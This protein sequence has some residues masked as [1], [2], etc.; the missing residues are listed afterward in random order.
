MNALKPFCMLTNVRYWRKADREAKRNTV[1][2]GR[3]VVSDPKG[4]LAPRVTA[5]GSERRRG[6]PFLRFHPIIKLAREALMKGLISR[7]FI[8]ALAAA[9]LVPLSPPHAHAAPV[10]EGDKA[11]CTPQKP[12]QEALETCSKI[13]ALPD[14]DSPTRAATLIARGNIYIKFKEFD[15][16][17]ADWEAAQQIKDFP[18]LS[19]ALGS[20]YINLGRSD[21]AIA[22]FT[23]LIDAGPPS[24]GLYN[25]RG[26]AYQNAGRFDDSIADFNRA[27]ALKPDDLMVLNNRGAAYWK[28][29]DLAA[30]MKDMD[31]VLAANPDMPTALVNRCQVLTR[32]GHFDQGRPSCDRA[33]Q[34]DP[35]NYFLLIAL[36]ATRYD[37]GQFEDAI[38]YCNRSLKLAPQNAP[39]LY[40][41]GL[42][43]AKL[44]LADES[45]LDMMEAERLQPDI[46]EFMAR[47]G[48]K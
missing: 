42:A 39:A 22:E 8:L 6:S 31:A 36:G 34:L 23:K 43:K 44:G 24:P 12:S 25:A 2:R 46:V 17:R 7:S 33:E 16:A 45:K 47:V 48:M 3:P 20:L 18:Q 27:L 21:Q 14:I 35:D 9:G 11:A 32:Q 37:A 15:L 30:A 10:T 5:G 41:R 29:G 28:K 40:V 19:M 4:F 1:V 13:L 38:S 26:S